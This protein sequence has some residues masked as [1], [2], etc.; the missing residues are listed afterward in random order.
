ME[1]RAFKIGGNGNSEN[2]DTCP[3]FPARST[4][5]LNFLSITSQEYR[6]RPAHIHEYMPPQYP[7]METE[8][9]EAPIAT[10]VFLP[11]AK[12][13][14]HAE[15]WVEKKVSYGFL[16]I[17]TSVYCV[18]WYVSI[19]FWAFMKNFMKNSHF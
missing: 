3:E 19:L 12:R 14:G 11:A 9:G 16:V 8:S 2:K 7:E 17:E 1:N 10:S 13:Q 6:S 4:S 15:L 5:D 18:F